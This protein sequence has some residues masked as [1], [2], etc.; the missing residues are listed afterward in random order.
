MIS[1][2]NSNRIMGMT[3]T[4]WYIYL[5][6]L[7][8]VALC[9]SNI[10]FFSY[11][12]DSKS[13]GHQTIIK[14]KVK[15][16]SFPECSSILEKI[17]TITA[18][19]SMYH[20]LLETSYATDDIEFAGYCLSVSYCVNNARLMKRMEEICPKIL[21]LDIGDSPRTQ[22]VHLMNTKV[23]YLVSNCRTQYFRQKLDICTPLGVRKSMTCAKNN[24]ARQYVASF[25]GQI[26]IKNNGRHRYTLKMLN[27][28]SDVL[29]KFSCDQLSNIKML[30]SYGSKYLRDA[31][32]EY[33]S[34]IKPTDYCQ[35]M[36][37][38]FVLCPGGRQPPS[39]RFT[40]ALI[41]NSI[42]VPY[43][44]SFDRDVPLPFHRV[45]DWGR[46]TKVYTDIGDVEK[47][48]QS[49]Q[50]VVASLL[51]GCSAIYQS[52]LSSFEAIMA[53]VNQ[54]LQII[55]K[56]RQTFTEVAIRY[57]LHSFLKL[58]VS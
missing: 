12:N 7:A 52:H 11:N 3:W 1:D 30:D 38:T 56:S 26:Y 37:A 34:S 35:S 51:Q 33:E 44:E 16:Y 9:I 58:F 29:I 48:I 10:S 15:F 54:E 25:V 28:T 17:N 41:V 47:L 14:D 53:T 20:G 24:L 18:T 42:P 31:C 8:L 46:C 22:K 39:Y 27:Q 36:N 50:K 43:Y 6:L 49:D 32:D 13:M 5:S 55:L 19:R 23:H 2:T 57:V 40:E 45:I 21:V 4:K